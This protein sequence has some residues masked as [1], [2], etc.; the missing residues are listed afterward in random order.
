MSDKCKT[1]QHEKCA[2]SD[3]NQ[4]RGSGGVGQKL[5]EGGQGHGILKCGT[6]EWD[7]VKC[8]GVWREHLGSREEEAR[9]GDDV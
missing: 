7:G 6:D 4:A 1:L 3:A 5:G 8:S 2:R 9:H